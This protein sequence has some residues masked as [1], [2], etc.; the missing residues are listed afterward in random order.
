MACR[1]RP[2]LL[3]VTHRGCTAHAVGPPRGRD[4][5]VLYKQPREEQ[6]EHR[7]HAHAPGPQG[8]QGRW[9]KAREAFRVE[10][11]AAALTA[12]RRMREEREG[13]QEVM[14]GEAWFEQLSP[15]EM[16]LFQSLMAEQAAA[17]PPPL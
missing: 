7:Q 16:T 11:M 8:A 17:P 13:A 12:F 10:G 15:N 4:A 2:A 1:L 6:L 5:Q 14:E 3:G 9:R